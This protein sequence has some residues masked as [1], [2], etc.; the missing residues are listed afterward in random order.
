[1]NTSLGA[2][3]EGERRRQRT[4]LAMAACAAAVVAAAATLLLGLSGW[5][6]TGAALAGVAGPA[7]ASAFNYMLPAVGIRLLAILRTLG[8]YGERVSGHD[9]ALRSLARL[10]PALFRAIVAGPVSTSLGLAVGDASMRMVQDV[11]AVEARFV[12]LSAP[13]G[14]GA[15]FVC[16]MAL[17]LPGGLAA[18][19][20]TALVLGATVAAAY[21]LSL[22][23]ERSG[24][25][26]QRAQAQ[27]KQE[28][29]TLIAASAEIRAYGLDGWAA[30]RIA[31]ESEALLIAQTRVTAWGGRFAL[32]QAMAPGL[33]AMV[34][35]AA[36][37]H[38][39][40]P[41]AAMAA[42]G[43]AMTVDG[44]GA[45]IRGVEVRGS[46]AESEARLDAVLSAPAPKPASR[47][48]HSPPDIEISALFSV[49][50]PGMVVGITGP[51]GCGKTTLLERLV[52]LRAEGGAR[53][54][55]GGVDIATIAPAT[56][57]ACFAHA[58]QDAALLAGTV[59][60]N[61]SLASPAATSDATLWAALRDAALDT[62]VR[63]LPAGLD[64]WIGENG[65]ALSGGERRRL[66]LARA[67][68]RSAPWL[69][70]D[71]PTAGLDAATEA[72]V[73][74]RLRARLERT[75]QGALIVSHRLAPLAICAIVR[76]IDGEP[77]EAI[78]AE[79]YRAVG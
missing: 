73:V 39:A 4:R 21:G 5:F 50:L 11:D 42:L 46:L 49:F 44:A 29:A 75:G 47:P 20:A 6:I 51:S 18:A 8:R 13:W 3:I 52:G 16:G 56:L 79:G 15:S 78:D 65:A 66:T 60:E 40:L 25:A 53:I 2:L 24:R 71:E 59:R 1:M 37:V 31:T 74:A 9:A 69:L 30:A 28:Y 14:A 45:F 27:L 22:L 63:G 62:R 61:L 36:S 34:A 70:L 55:I 23:S 33:A 64:T 48:L 35:M 76:R 72:T 10:R 68:L 38:A 26:V 12:R 41:I 43:A 32:L 17:L 58:P 57:R 67:Y 54:A 19:A 7:V 77:A